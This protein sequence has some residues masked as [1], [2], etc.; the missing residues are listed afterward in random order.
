MTD[1]VA[2][3]GMGMVP[4]RSPDGR[5]VSVPEKHAHTYVERGFTI[6]DEAAAKRV[7]A[8]MRRGA[9]PAGAPE[10]AP[11][12]VMAT[13]PDGRKV[14]I[15]SKLAE[16][17]LGRGFTI[18]GRQAQPE[19]LSTRVAS[20]GEVVMRSSDG[21]DVPVAAK[22]VGQYLDRGWELSPEQPVVEAAP[23][24][25]VLPEQMGPGLAPPNAGGDHAGTSY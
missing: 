24:D 15:N 20:P 2:G 6:T 21:R 13:S 16:E 7:A 4:A 11:G 25:D 1:P 9:K 10:L 3:G 14:A 8:A 17:Y 18:A 22:M 12:Q 5:D 23:T 19:A